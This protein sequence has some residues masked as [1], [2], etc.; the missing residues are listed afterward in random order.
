[1][2]SPFSILAR[3]ERDPNWTARRDSTIRDFAIPDPMIQGFA[4]QDS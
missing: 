3:R 4:D 1:M 2:A